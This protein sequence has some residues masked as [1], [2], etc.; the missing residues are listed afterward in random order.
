MFIVASIASLLSLGLVVALKS[1]VVAVGRDRTRLV[2][3]NASGLIVASPAAWSF[4]LMVQQM[5]G[6]RMGSSW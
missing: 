6:I 5:A 2:L 4:L 1:G 3:E